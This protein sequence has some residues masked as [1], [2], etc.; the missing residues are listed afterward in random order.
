M[1]KQTILEM[2]S[3]YSHTSVTYLIILALILIL[4]AVTGYIF[5]SNARHKKIMFELEKSENNYKKMFQCM[6]EGIALFQIESDKDGEPENYYLIDANPAFE[7]IV[8]INK[9]EAINHTISEL[10]SHADIGKIEK[11]DKVA[12]TGEP[13]K[14]ESYF[15]NIGKHLSINIYKPEQDKL[16]VIFSDITQ[17]KLAEELVNKQK[18]SFE[19]LFKNS[20]DAIILF[21]R[22][23]EVLD[24]NEKFTDLFGFTIDDI[25]GKEVDSIVASKGKLEEANQLTVDV[26]NGHDVSMES[27][28]FGAD[29]QPREVSVKGVVIKSSNTIIGGFG[30]YADISQ[31]KKAEKEI[32]F[33]NYHDQLTGLYNR[34]FFE[35]ELKRIDIER[36]LPISLI[37]ADVNGLKLINDA[38]GHAYGDMLLIK[39]GELIKNECRQDEIIARLGGDEF[40]ILL[41]KTSPEEAEKITK[42]IKESSSGIKL[43]SMEL[44]ISFGWAT[45]S[46]IIQDINETLKNAEDYMYRH[47]LFESPS[48]RGKTVKAIINSLH[49]KNKREEQHSRRVSYL[50]EAIG[51]AMEQN[52]SGLKELKTVGLLHDIGKI[53]IDEKILNKPDRLTNEEWSDMKRHPEIGYRILSSVNDMAELAEFVLAHHER[54]DGKGY[55]KGLKGKEI[56]LQARII[57]VADTFDAMTSAR[58][59]RSPLSDE[60]AINEIEKNSGTQFDPEIVRVFIEKVM[61]KKIINDYG[62]QVS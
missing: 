34:R 3:L 55:P 2:G 35:E 32:L 58:P 26:L 61:N 22:H 40:V 27:I 50:C 5:K 19:A 42:R 52:E 29:G 12:T 59:Y 45:K 20:S 8:E 46:H 7:Y 14:Y 21:D 37:M 36:N 47:K 4:V 54:W 53:A 16:A 28:R 30:I 60:T 25:R 15:N 1:L 24:I 48:I 44:S 57:M 11:L 56:P 18:L 13:A 31:R 17:K 23:H 43:Q 39:T 10:L 62:G 33:I 51:I 41:P 6:Q 38:F 9:D 49:E